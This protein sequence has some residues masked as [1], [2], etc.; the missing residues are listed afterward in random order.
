M[1]F[2]SYVLTRTVSVGGA[3]ILESSDPLRIR[4][5]ITAS[6]SLINA[7]TGYRFKNSRFVTTSEAGTDAVAVLPRTDMSGWKDARTG[8]IID[9]TA[10]GSYT[11]QYIALVEYLTADGDSAGISPD[12]IGPF[13]VPAGDGAID[14]DKLIPVGS[15][16]GE[17]ISFPAYWDELVQQAQAS[18][19][20]AQAALLDSAD[21]IGSEIAR[22]GSPAEQALLP[23]IAE[24][25]GGSGVSLESAQRQANLAGQ[26]DAAMLATALVGAVVTHAAG[27]ATFSGAV[28]QKAW[29]RADSVLNANLR[30][31]GATAVAGGTS[32]PRYDH[33]TSDTGP[34]KVQ[35]R[36]AE[37]GTRIAFGYFTRNT[38]FR[39]ALYA[40]GPFQE[41][42]R[43]A[44]WAAPA[45]AGQPNRTVVTMPYASTWEFSLEVVS[46]QDIASIFYE[47]AAPIAAPLSAAG[48][49][50]L[51]AGDSFTGAA[52][53]AS[54]LDGYALVLSRVMKWF[55]LI[56]S[57]IGGTGYLTD[58]GAGSPSL[59]TRLD[60]DIARNADIF[61][62]A[63][64]INDQGRG[65]T[66][67]EIIAAA[68][69]CWDRVIAG[70]PRTQ[71]VVLG[72]WWPRSGT[73]T[74]IVE[75]DAGFR[76]EAKKRGLPFISPL[77]EKWITG[78]GTTAAPAGD[79]NADIYISADGTHPSTAGHRYLAMRLAGWLLSL[80]IGAAG[81][82]STGLQIPA[83]ALPNYLSLPGLIGLIQL[84]GGT[85]DGGTPPTPTDPTWSI[86]DTF[87][88]ADT[89]TDPGVTETGSKAWAATGINGN[90][91]VSGGRLRLGSTTR[92][93]V[94]VDTASVDGH[95]RCVATSAPSVKVGGL[96]LRMTDAANGLFVSYNDTGT[97]G[98]TDLT[99]TLL[100]IVGGTVTKLATST[101]A[102]VNGDTIDVYANGAT[103]R[104]YVNG[105][106]TLSTTSAPAMTGTKW[107]VGVG[108]SGGNSNQWDD[109]RWVADATLPA[110]P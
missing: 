37:P 41:R 14:L 95:A 94:V 79:G 81:Q 38:A 33:V 65:R 96:W 27:T 13:I 24:L 70:N 62:F 53:A 11:H 69:A 72:P 36:L 66:S 103:V 31:L 98:S 47:P 18:A 7:E 75:L 57:A 82:A 22:S 78:S 42:V 61:V 54:Q 30:V 6:K 58:N 46:S 97:S 91:Y 55:D 34:Y 3:A 104:V 110:V 51:I 63:M 73:T 52:G 32:S 88:R 76:A 59:T 49:R 74:Q 19:A 25:V 35:T 16:S 109:F 107:G 28:E 67:A 85:G 10:E 4:L 71:V 21:F 108:G 87:T 39:F 93:G 100:S 23:K 92:G 1:A 77:T 56:P 26:R 80:A 83:G 20:A 44:E 40:Q 90:G 50:V 15:S 48:P 64:G 29:N 86:V 106:L 9:I 84:Y 60:G 101:L 68:A 43:L 8:D 5:T 89:T 12:T 105:A 17:S 2:P 45:A 99:Y 102:Q